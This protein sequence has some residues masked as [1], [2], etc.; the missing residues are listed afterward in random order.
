MINLLPPSEKRQIIAGQTNVLLWRYCITSLLLAGLLLAVT[1]GVYFMMIRS[2]AGAEET[3]ASS[4][5]VAIKYQ[6][7]QRQS[8]EFSSN[9]ATAKTILGKEVRYSK[10]AVSIAQALPSGVV[11]ESLNLDAKTFGTPIVINAMG[12]NYDDS[13]RLKT[14]L[15]KSGSFKDVHL[16][17]VAQEAGENVGEYPVSIAITVT[18]DPEVAKQ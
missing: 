6:E 15:E 4:N 3:I 5:Q 12:K 16:S 18:I 8:T 17:S 13:L 2:K 10:I 14:S 7:I 9:L 11:L 1:G